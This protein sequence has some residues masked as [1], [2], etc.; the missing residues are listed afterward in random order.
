MKTIG[1][2]VGDL[3][4]TKEGSKEEMTLGLE[5]RQLFRRM[6]R[7]IVAESLR[8]G[9]S[10]E[11]HAVLSNQ[12]REGLKQRMQ[13]GICWERE[14]GPLHGEYVWMDAKEFGLSSQSPVLY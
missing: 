2:V 6:R 9:Q 1:R 3:I 10:S 8:T 12:R 14:L 4:L 11:K 5:G 7:K 13:N